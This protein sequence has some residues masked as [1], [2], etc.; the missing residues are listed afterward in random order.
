MLYFGNSYINRLYR[1]VFALSQTIKWKFR[2]NRSSKK[3]PCSR[4]GF[5]M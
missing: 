3:T 2:S 1:A 4:R 5:F